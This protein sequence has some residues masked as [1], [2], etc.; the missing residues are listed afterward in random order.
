M[1][2]PLLFDPK[3]LDILEAEDRKLWQDPE[4]ILGEIEFDRDYVAADLGC[5]SGFFTLP[6]SRR[7]KKVYGIDVQ[8]EMLEFVAKKIK[9][10]KIG[11]VELLLSEENE[12]PLENQSVDLLLSANTLHEFRDKEKM[13]REI[14]RVL[15]PNGKAAIVDFKKEATDFGPP[16]AIR[17]SR[18]Q[19]RQLFEKNGFKALK[20]RDLKYHYLIV[21]LNSHPI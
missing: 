1:N 15:K 19:A 10:E 6:L 9:G 3:N 8:A 17:L 20:S 12:I 13:V 5:G 2:N 14:Q 21:F 18:E 4:E 11:N 16:V 7:V